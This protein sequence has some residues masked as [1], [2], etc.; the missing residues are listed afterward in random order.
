MQFITIADR[1]MASPHVIDLERLL[2]PVSEDQPAGPELRTTDGE[3]QRIYYA[4]RDARKKAGDAERR[5]RMFEL[6]TDAEKELE[7]AAPDPADWD[8]VGELA[9][10]ALERSKDLWICAWLIEA[11]TRSHGFAGLRDGYRLARGLC[12]G[13]WSQVHPQPR[14][15]EDLSTLFAQLAGLNGIDSDGTLIAPIMKVPVTGNTAAGQFSTSDYTDAADLERKG[16]DV[17]NQR[18]Q[19]GAVT[20]EMFNRA[21]K[22]TSVEFFRNLLD[23]LQQAI[24]EFQAFGDE[25]GSKLADIPNSGSLLPPT[26]SIQEA[27][28]E[29]LRLVKFVTREVLGSDDEEDP[30]N[31][32]MTV[33]E[34]GSASA[35]ATSRVQTREDAFRALLQVSDFFRRTEPHSPVSYAVEQAVRWGRM[36]L[37]ELLSELVGDESIRRDI[38]KRTGIGQDSGD[39]D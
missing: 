3:D 10:Q 5:N 37:P 15:S 13:Y 16:Q 24:G 18:I 12:S 7:P 35:V 20:M 14:D 34:G 11:L 2:A 25:I 21:I 4:V 33:V 38:F 22:E 27:L 9:I 32:A 8:A 6:L 30:G 29:C 36:N 23:D 31:T 17:R 28:D 1:Y 39:D 26:S 19:H